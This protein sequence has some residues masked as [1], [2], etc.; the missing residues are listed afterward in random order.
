MDP[1][2][3]LTV[4]AVIAVLSALVMCIFL[5]WGSDRLPLKLDITKDQHNQALKIAKQESSISALDQ[6][7]WTSLETVTNEN[8]T[9]YLRLLS[10]EFYYDNAAIY[11]RIERLPYVAD[12]QMIFQSL[13]IGWT[14]TYSIT[15][16]AH[17]KFNA[18]HKILIAKISK[19]ISLPWS[20]WLWGV[21]YTDSKQIE[22]M[23]TELSPAVGKKHMDNMLMSLL[24]DKLQKRHKDDLEISFA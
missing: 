6:N 19:K 18:G 4:G 15:V 21:T 7:Y 2:T 23:L 9:S 17:K 10:K 16:I 8:F 22:E 12:S 24:V 11:H 1:T 14:N 3:H 13:S 5:P 20:R